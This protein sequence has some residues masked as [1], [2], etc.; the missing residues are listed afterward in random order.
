MNKIINS[1]VK[2]LDKYTHK[3]SCVCPFCNHINIKYIMVYGF[4]NCLVNNDLC[5][6]FFY[7]T[8]NLKSICFEQK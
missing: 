4:I 3:I 8:A 1:K 7:I 6:H 2:K 5:Q